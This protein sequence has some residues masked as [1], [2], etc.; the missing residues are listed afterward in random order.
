MH[1]SDYIKR[2]VEITGE[3]QREYSD[4]DDNFDAIAEI[5]SA[6][7]GRAITRFEV[8]MILIAVKFGRLRANPAHEDSWS[9]AINYVAFSAQFA[10]RPPEPSSYDFQKKF[11]ES[12]L[13]GEEFVPTP[14]TAN[15]Y[16]P[17]PVDPD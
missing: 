3:R 5:A 9:D 8:A 15:E 1:Y 6:L 16:Q 12:L 2:A 11:A 14:R 17:V 4:V 7:L 10:P 13:N